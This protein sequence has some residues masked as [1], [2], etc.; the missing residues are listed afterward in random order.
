[1]GEDTYTVVK[2]EYPEV[3]EAYKQF[4][5]NF[6]EVRL[7]RDQDKLIGNLRGALSRFLGLEGPDDAEVALRRE[8]DEK[9]D[10][11]ASPSMPAGASA[12]MDKAASDLSSAKEPET[13]KEATNEVPKETVDKVF[14]VLKTDVSR[15]RRDLNDSLKVLEQYE[16]Q[17]DK[18]VYAAGLVLKRL[19]R[20][21][22]DV[23]DSNRKIIIDLTKLAP[24]YK[25]KLDEAKESREEKIQKVEAAYDDIVKLMDSIIDRTLPDMEEEP[26][27]KAA[28][29]ETPSG[30]S[31]E[32]QKGATNKGVLDP[33]FKTD[34]PPTPSTP[35]D[36]ANQFEEQIY[37]KVLNLLKEEE[38]STD[39]G[40][41]ESFVQIAA[42]ALNA[43]NGIKKYFRVTGTF[44]KPLPQVKKEFSSLIKGYK[45]TLSDLLVDMRQKRVTTDNIQKYI[46][47]F[48]T[49]TSKIVEY[50]GISPR[51]PVVLKKPDGEVINIPSADSADTDSTAA[52]SKAGEG[53]AD[54]TEASPKDVTE[55]ETPIDE[56]RTFYNDNTKFY[57][58]V[59]R[60]YDVLKSE[61]ID[62]KE[63][64]QVKEMI[65]DFK[66]FSLEEELGEEKIF[67]KLTKIRQGLLLMFQEADIV[68]LVKLNGPK[69]RDVA[70]EF[71][72]L[73]LLARK[74]II[75]DDKKS[76]E[77]KVE[78]EPKIEAKKKTFIEKL[79][80]LFKGDK[81]EETLID[82]GVKPET[83]KKIKAITADAV[84]EIKKDEAESST[85]ADEQNVDKSPK[86]TEEPADDKNTKEL[87]ESKNLLERLIRQELKVLNGKKMV[88]N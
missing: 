43:I 58:V 19:K 86:A 6:L 37:R 63:L 64:K 27:E 76:K 33:N 74:M 77:E 65:V 70:K 35:T 28:D 85:D 73:M 14:G 26:R 54:D 61:T 30:N 23:Q 4:K 32:S 71:I 75:A 41:I 24:D 5:D 2:E 3:Q 11:D 22:T 67:Q 47:M 8:A 9:I 55:F 36:Y 51:E 72:N 15:L 18:G 38:E 46:E 78:I 42:N 88:R 87:E 53:E 49:L 62:A 16:K 1:M 20:E 69:I 40:E 48:T 52:V 56:L 31:P 82:S 44:N 13:S 80:A 50:F 34:L 57:R 84:K 12:A 29:T 68:E 81:Q 7:L 79:I 25:F 17:A 60:L 10:T 59:K 66:G 45:K 83:V 21:L 39:A